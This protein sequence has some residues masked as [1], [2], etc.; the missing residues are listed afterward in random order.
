MRSGTLSLA[1]AH[2]STLPLEEALTQIARITVQAIH[3]SDGAGLALLKTKGDPTVVASTS[4]V[5]EIDAIQ[6]QLGQGPCLSAVV[7]DRPVRSGSLT[8]DT[9]WPKFAARVARLGINSAHSSLSLPLRLP[10][11][12]IGS[13]NIYAHAQHAFN[14]DSIRRGEDFAMV[15]AVAVSN[16]SALSQLRIYS[17]QLETALTSRATI[18]QAIGIIRSRTGGTSEEAFD[19]L[20]VISQ[21]ENRK[22]SEVAAHLLDQST[23]RA[24]ARHS[25]A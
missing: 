17:I 10:G 21:R 9:R 22:L 7:D 20:R 15:A 13:L 6:Y 1:L 12:V 14:D 24:R 18:D 25:H 3:G 11:T 23:G 16:L 19:S 4:F 5:G 8:N 2:T